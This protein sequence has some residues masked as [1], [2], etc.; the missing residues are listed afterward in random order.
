MLYELAELQLELSEG[1]SSAALLNLPSSNSNSL[2]VSQVPLELSQLQLELSEGQ[3][4]AFRT[5]RA[6]TIVRSIKYTDPIFTVLLIGR[7]VCY[8]NM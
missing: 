5:C 4:S 7:V 6:P 8:I 2:K 1:Q 3:L